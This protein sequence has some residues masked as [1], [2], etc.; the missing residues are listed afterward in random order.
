MSPNFEKVRTFYKHK[1]WTLA[2]VK[3]AVE[4]NWITKEEFKTITGQ[5]Y[6]K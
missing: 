2:Q 6:S 1:L 3:K 4:C 5:N